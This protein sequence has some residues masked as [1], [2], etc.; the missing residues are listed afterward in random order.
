MHQFFAV[1]P[2]FDWQQ[3]GTIVTVT[4]DLL[5]LLA[6]TLTIRVGFQQKAFGIPSLAI[7]FNFSWEFIYVVLEPSQNSLKYYLDLSW[8]IT[9]SVIVY[10][11]FRYG[12]DLQRVPQMKKY[13]YPAMIVTMAFC[14]IGQLAYHREYLGSDPYGYQ[15]A[16][17][18]NLLMSI[19]FIFLYFERQGL[20]GL[21]YGAAWAKMLG[22]GVLSLGTFIS[23]LHDKVQAPYM[24]FLFVTIFICDLFYIYLL[25]ST[26]A[27]AVPPNDAFRAGV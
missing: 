5:W 23:F 12:K 9:D 27:Q 7:C 16:Y 21:S 3:F 17:N 22:T 6:Y 8:L 15:A 1:Q 2:A 24:E 19:L 20:R 25:H 10:Q 14:F 13:F 18:I 11:L 26:Q 4:G